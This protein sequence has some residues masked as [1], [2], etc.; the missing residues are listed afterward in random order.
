MKSKYPV[1]IITL[2]FLIAFCA[3]LVPLQF[4]DLPYNIDGFP[5]A[6]ISEIIISDGALPD[7][8]NYG[9]L[10]AYNMKLPVFP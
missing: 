6:R 4:S 5:L 3:R 7:P 10:L 2:L 9:G 1:L 8:G